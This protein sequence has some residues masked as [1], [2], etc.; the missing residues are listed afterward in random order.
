MVTSGDEGEGVI[1]K[2]WATCG[3]SKVPGMFCKQVRRHSFCFSTLHCTCVMWLFRNKG[4]ANDNSKNPD[5]G[6]G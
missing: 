1:R 6:I 5:S 3:T 4:E 2:G